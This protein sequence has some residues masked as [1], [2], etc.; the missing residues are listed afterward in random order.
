[1][2]ISL[3][4]HSPKSQNLKGISEARKTFLDLNRKF[5]FCDCQWDLQKAFQLLF[6]SSLHLFKDDS[7]DQGPDDQIL[8]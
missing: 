5:L 8:L 4:P 6:S 2:H 3:E 1:M 7:D